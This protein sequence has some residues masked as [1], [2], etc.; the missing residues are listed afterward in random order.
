MPF[1]VLKYEKNKEN[2][3]N[4]N[5]LIRIMKKKI[6]ALSISLSV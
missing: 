1:Q 3:K 5:I 6:K 4:E 2:E